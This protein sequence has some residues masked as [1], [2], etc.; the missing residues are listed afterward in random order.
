[1]LEQVA[2]TRFHGALAAGLD[3]EVIGDR[4]HLSDFAVG[5]RENRPRGVTIACA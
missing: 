4:A 5:L 1:M 2:E 3:V